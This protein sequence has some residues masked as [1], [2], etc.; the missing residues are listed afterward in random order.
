MGFLSNTRRALS[1]FLN[2]DKG[3][4]N[5]VAQAF[6]GL[7]GNNFTAYDTNAPTYI[8]KGYLYNPI[9]Y[10]IVNQQA[11]KAKS[12]PFNIRKIDDN[13]AKGKL[14][15]LRLATKGAY[16]IPQFIKVLSLENKAFDEKEYNFPLD[17]PNELQTWSEI[18]AL[19]QTFMATTGNFYLYMLR[20]DIMTEP[21][22]VYVLPAHL[23]NIVLKPQANTLGVES[24]IDC[25]RLIEGNMYVDFKADDVIHI[26]LPNPDYGQNGEHLY[27]LSP[28][29]AALRNIQSS[30]LAIDGNTKIMLN[31]GAF[32]FI[33]GKGQTAMTPDQA[34]EIKSRLQEMDLSNERL[35]KIAGVSAELGFTRIALT[36]DELKPFDYLKYDQ[37]Q[38]AN[39]LG[40]DDKLLNNDDG[41]KYDNV[42][43]AQKGV[44]INTIMPS[45]KLLEEA[46]TDRFLPLFKGYDGTC[47][48]FDYSELPEMQIDIADMVGWLKDALDRGVINRNE[49]RKAIKYPSLDNEDME[50]FTVQNDIIPLSEA[51]DDTFR[52]DQAAI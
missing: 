52:I 25:Y 49:F 23:M 24:P 37:K 10:S 16:T 39:V 18:I 13:Q 15:R 46:L 6:Y 21:L 28:L 45:L 19:Y 50:E 33:H 51:I 42:S 20:G 36:T 40:W 11:N 29:K 27:G 4:Y 9:V 44:I 5:A 41:A 47:L 8:D 7:I 31:S 38:I 14:D 22:Q 1:T 43:L 34:K 35:G 3:V 32:G 30:N 26:K 48:E 2:P 17:K 12:I